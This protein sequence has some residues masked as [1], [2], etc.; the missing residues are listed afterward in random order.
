MTKV[1]RTSSAAVLPLVAAAVGLGVGATPAD[2]AICSPLS[3]ASISGPSGTI[4][5]GSI[6]HA[7][8]SVSGML[9]TAHM[10]ITGPGL[11]RQVGPSAISGTI[12]GAVRVP[13]PGV[14]TLRVLGNG[15]GCVYDSDAFSVK[16]RPSASSPSPGGAAAGAPSAPG[17]SRASRAPKGTRDGATSGL[18]APSSRMPFRL[19]PVAPDGTGPSVR[20]PSVDP[21]VAAP[22]VK[23]TQPRAD[24]AAETLPRIKWGQSIAIALVLLLLSA[25]M[26]MWSRRQRLAEAGGRRRGARRATTDQQM[27]ARM[28]LASDHPAVPRDTGRPATPEDRD[29]PPPFHAGYTGTQGRHGHVQDTPSADRP[30][31][32]Y[33]AGHS[34][35]IGGESRDDQRSRTVGRSGTVSQNGWA[36]PPS[37]ATG[38][39]PTTG[40]TESGTVDWESWVATRRQMDTEDR[41]DSRRWADPADRDARVGPENRDTQV[42]PNGRAPRQPGQYPLDGSARPGR[43]DGGDIMHGDSAHATGWAAAPAMNA[44]GGRDLGTEAGRVGSSGRGGAAVSLDRATRSGRGRGAYRGRRRR[45]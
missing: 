6:V 29:T 36:D 20:Y 35:M 37:Q 40:S 30:G 7:S 33:P 12:E 39:S 10:Q 38:Q 17:A 34:G 15:T 31:T 16:A 43:A 42:Y 32:A 9:L 14:F 45:S 24:N 1:R 25:H 19:P 2:A 28:P 18:R 8:A 41:A 23:Q 27:T 13:E 26:G 21:Q 44:V 11:D 22:P 5:A 3:S 4:T